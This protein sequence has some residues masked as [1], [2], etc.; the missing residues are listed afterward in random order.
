[1]K[2]KTMLPFLE[3]DELKELAQKVAASPDGN[4]EGITMGN[5]LPFLEE[6]D[7]DAMMLAAYQKKTSPAICYPFAS[8]EGLS[9]LL[10]MVLDADDEEFDLLPLFPFLEDEDLEAL[11]SKII[12]KGHPFGR[13][14]FESLLPFLDDDKIDQAFLSRLKAHDPEANKMAPFVSD[15]CFHELVKEYAAGTLQDV[16]WDTYYPYL[17]SKDLHLLFEAEMAR[18]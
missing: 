14:S 6:E 3:E 1:M 15:H 8:E 13:V 7:V 4:Y 17:D 12:A 9:K 5:L 18:H 10:K 11:A 16:D 2:L